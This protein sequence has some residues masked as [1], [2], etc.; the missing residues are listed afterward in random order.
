MVLHAEFPQWPVIGKDLEGRSFRVVQEAK[1]LGLVYGRLNSVAAAVFRERSGKIHS[2]MNQYMG[3]LDFSRVSF[4]LLHFCEK[5]RTKKILDT[6]VYVAF[7]N[8]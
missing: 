8:I 5:Q 3:I 1:T 7:F 6:I 2:T 4:L